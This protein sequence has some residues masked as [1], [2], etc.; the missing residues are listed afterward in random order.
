MDQEEKVKLAL[1]LQDRMSLNFFFDDGALREDKLDE[2]I[3][4]VLEGLRES[5]KQTDRT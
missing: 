5:I 2:L 4:I 1:K 3:I